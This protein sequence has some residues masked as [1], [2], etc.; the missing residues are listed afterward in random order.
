MCERSRVV[1]ELDPVGLQIGCTIKIETKLRDPPGLGIGQLAVVEL[2]RIAA[3]LLLRTVQQV[4]IRSTCQQPLTGLLVHFHHSLD[5]VPIVRSGRIVAQLQDGLVHA[6]A[7]RGRLLAEI[8]PPAVRCQLPF[9]LVGTQLRLVDRVAQLA[10][11]LVHRRAEGFRR[12]Q[13]HRRTGLRHDPGIVAFLNRHGSTLP[14]GGQLPGMGRTP[15][16][17]GTDQLCPSA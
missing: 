16:R 9:D 4:F 17:I 8:R 7:V 11:A 3:Q 6:L 5:M 13:R 15:V 1:A 14:A 12:G 10:S 2:A